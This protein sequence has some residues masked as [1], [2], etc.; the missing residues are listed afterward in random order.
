MDE[1]ADFFRTLQGLCRRFESTEVGHAV[2]YCDSSLGDFDLGHVLICLTRPLPV[3]IQAGGPDR[4][5]GST[6]SET[7]VTV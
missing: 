2:L 6:V 1:L 3:R 7:I 5:V 4:T